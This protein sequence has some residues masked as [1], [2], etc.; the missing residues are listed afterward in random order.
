[1]T[2]QDDS[3]KASGGAVNSDEVTVIGGGLAGMAAA[4]ELNRLGLSVRLLEASEDLGGKAGSRRIDG[5]TEDHG[6]HVFPVFYHNTHR[7]LA[8]L[9]LSGSLRPTSK[10][11]QIRP[12]QLGAKG[13]KAKGAP[14]APVAEGV[15]FLYGVLD[16][17]A[18]DYR[19]R[20]ESLYDFLHSRTYLTD[21]AKSDF[22]HFFLASTASEVRVASAAEFRGS[23]AAFMRRPGRIRMPRGDLQHW[24]IDPWRRRLEAKG[25]KVHTGYELTGV[26]TSGDRLDTLTL[27]TG[28]TTTTEPVNGHV[29]LAL[30]HDQVTA[31][32][33]GLTGELRP[34]HGIRE[35]NSRP[36]GALHLYLRRRLPHLPPDHVRLVDSPH[37]ITLLDVG[38][39][40]AGHRTSVLN[41]VSGRIDRLA[42]LPE[43]EVVAI[44]VEEMR[45]YLPGLDPADIE[46]V[47]FQPHTKA[48]YFTP[49]PGADSYRPSNTT[50]LTNLH[51]AGDYTAAPPGMT[52]MEGAVSSGM[53][54]AESVRRVLCPQETPVRVDPIPGIKPSTARMIRRALSPLAAIARARTAPLRRQP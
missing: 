5:R 13:R 23:I 18:Q 32:G 9:G 20:D 22:E 37:A 28:D 50:A 15:L 51:L 25:T 30:P 42:H 21:R 4:W 16:L 35:L 7:L 33:P 46:H 34:A 36:L 47:C 44:L 3:L 31:F 54:A 19:T 12:G 49:C 26:T 38:Q 40:W 6:V 17:V 43:S 29:V 11:H 52:G 41:C 10:F 48:P 8:E 45:D 27:R 14:A 24:L 1:M 2:H 39:S 53:R